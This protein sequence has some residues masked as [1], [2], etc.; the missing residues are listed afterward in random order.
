MKKKWK[1]FPKWAKVIAVF[2]VFLIISEVILRFV[3]G[4][5][6]FP[7]YRVDKNYEYIYESNQ[8]VY[9]YGNHI[10]TN[11]FGMRS[12]SINK[13]RKFTI[14]EFGDS[15]LNGGAHVDQDELST[16]I[17]ENDLSEK[18]EV[19][20]QVLNVSAQ[21]W[22]VSNAFAFLKKHGNFKADLIVLVFSSHDLNDNM[23]F[24]DVVGEHPAWPDKKPWL[25]I[26][27]A[28]SRLI[29]PTLSRFFTGDDEY[30]YLRDFDDSKVNPGWINFFNYSSETNIPLI[31]YLHASKEEVKNGRYNQ[32]G[33]KIIKLCSEN[34]IKLITDLK[35]MENNEDAYIDDLHLN[36]KGHEIMAELIL[37]EL[38]NE[39]EEL[40]PN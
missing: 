3:I 36:G 23:H 6:D 16:T 27:D 31:V 26:T 2:F 34:S 11:E 25:A 22:G 20:I 29:W 7:V 32:L 15:V 40:S 10:V 21:S 8:D 19:P 24:R 17:E 9:R 5:G 28:W 33:N 37:P 18:Y 39:L 35:N 12:K 14:L 13:K 38:E 1:S 4:L 30:E